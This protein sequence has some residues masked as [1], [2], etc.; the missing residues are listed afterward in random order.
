[1]RAVRP[2]FELW[3]EVRAEEERMVGEL[4]DFDQSAVRR[5]P[6]EA[7]AMLREQLAV[8]VVEL[9]AMTVAFE[10]DRLRV[11]ARSERRVLEHARV[12]ADAHR[13]GL[14]GDGTPL[15]QDGDQRVARAR[16]EIRRSARF[17]AERGGRA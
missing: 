7:H 14:V 11:R 10:H 4:D 16:A 5:E 17:W 1:M 13:P 9:V 6:R 12:A 8:R 3:M 15:R 2:R